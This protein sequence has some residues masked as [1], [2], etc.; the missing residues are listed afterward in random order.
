MKFIFIIM[1]VLGVWALGD[2]YEELMP[3]GLSLC[4]QWEQK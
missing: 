3:I 2:I 4:N 1:A